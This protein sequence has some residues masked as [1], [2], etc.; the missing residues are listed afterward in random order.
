MSSRCDSP[1]KS[2]VNACA[3]SSFLPQDTLFITSRF[4]PINIW[5]WIPTTA[6][7]IYP[8][9]LPSISHLVS[10]SIHPALDISLH[11]D[12]LPAHTHVFAI[13]M[14]ASECIPLCFPI[15][16]G[17]HHRGIMGHWYELSVLLSVSEQR[18][19]SIRLGTVAIQA[20]QCCPTPSFNVVF[21]FYLSLITVN[22]K[23]GY[24]VSDF[25]VIIRRWDYFTYLCRLSTW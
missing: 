3:G 1:V 6:I 20:N 10:A 14:H 18:I 24:C 9:P 21:T 15:H 13:L 19:T 11:M 5:K 4:L 22:L 23:T 25:T 8:R 16:V 12:T 7:N 17:R 2:T